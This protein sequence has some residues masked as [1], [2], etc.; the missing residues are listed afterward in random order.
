MLYLF[1]ITPRE[2]T[3]TS[4]WQLQ[5]DRVQLITRNFLAAR[6]I[7]QWNELSGKERYESAIIEGTE[8]E[9]RLPGGDIKPSG[10]TGRP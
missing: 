5:T 10:G 8:A 2:G 3:R 4:W 1:N 6:G 7:Q 9:V